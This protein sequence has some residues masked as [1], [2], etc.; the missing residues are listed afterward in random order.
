M[1]ASNQENIPTWQELIGD[2]ILIELKLQFV[3]NFSAE[4]FDVIMEGQLFENFGYEV[5]SVIRMA[6]MRKES[7]Y[8]DVE[9]VNEMI[10]RYNKIVDN[11]TAS[12]VGFIFFVIILFRYHFI[13]F[14]ALFSA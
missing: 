5:N 2:A 13:R 3:V 14:V 8:K 9:R 6:I 11:L 7:L 10:N 1:D 4:I 12:E